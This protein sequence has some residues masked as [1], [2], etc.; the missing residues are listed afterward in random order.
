MHAIPDTWQ[1]VFAYTYTIRYN[2][3][4]QTGVSVCFLLLF[5]LTFICTE[6]FTSLF[7]WYKTSCLRDYLFVFAAALQIQ[8]TTSPWS[9]CINKW[10]N[11]L[12]T[13]E[14]NSRLF[15]PKW[16]VIE[17]SKQTKSIC[18][19]HFSLNKLIV[20]DTR[21]NPTAETINSPL[22]RSFITSLPRHNFAI[23][24]IKLGIR[25]RGWLNTHRYSPD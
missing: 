6:R 12:D 14:N 8:T 10:H 17:T 13:R 2:T 18:W 23:C 20:P 9:P 25:E 24:V 22:S 5:A 16:D 11:F 4:S 3:S 21:I 19:R 15:L 7:H 1:N